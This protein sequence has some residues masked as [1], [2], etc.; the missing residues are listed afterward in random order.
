MDGTASLGGRTAKGRK[1]L[2][3]QGQDFRSRVKGGRTCRTNQSN[4]VDVLMLPETVSK[5]L[6]TIG[7][8]SRQ[9]KRI[10]GLTRLMESPILWEKAYSEIASNKGAL[11]RGVT[12]NTLDGFS[13]ER[14]ANLAERVRSGNHRFTPVRR[15]YIPKAN[16]KKRP[17]GVPT[18][19]D[20]L[21]QGV[22]K[23]LLELMYEPLFSPHSHGFRRNFSCHTA[24]EKIKN[25]WT[26]VKWF[27][28]VDVVG[29]FDNIDHDILIRLLEKRIDD[30]RFINLVRGM[31]KAGYMEDWKFH[32]TMSGTPQG[33]IVS[34]ILANIYLHEL[35]LFMEEM[36][37]RYD[38]GKMRAFT[39][40]YRTL[41][42]AIRLNR[43]KADRMFAQG[44]IT[45]GEQ[46]KQKVARLAA[47]RRSMPAKDGFDPNYRRLLF[48]RY[49][50]DF[51]IGIIGPK[52]EA[53]EIMQEVVDYLRRHL[54]LEASPEKS[55]ITK[56][57]RGTI[58]LGYGIKTA[59]ANRLR[60]TR[61]GGRLV[62]MR[63]PG[64]RIR[65]L[66]PSERT[67]RFN[68]EKGYGDLCR[69]KAVHRSY[70]IDSSALEIVM[71]YNAEM[72]G[73]ANYYRLA[74]F[75]KNDLRKLYFLWRTSLLRTLASKF[76]SS[77]SKVVRQFRAGREL[78]VSVKI[79]DKERGATVFTLKEIDQLPKLG[80]SV[81]IKPVVQFTKARS[82]VL[83]RL[84]AQVCEYCGAQGRPCEVHHVRRLVDMKGTELW[85]QVAAARRRKRVV[86]CRPCH[87]A[88]HAGK[89]TRKQVTDT[90]DRRA[91]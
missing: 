32:S 48:C 2:G 52:A 23:L 27:V 53:R 33:G 26:G 56:A 61:I 73:F 9:G 45:E 10:N 89:L 58:F 11:T 4:M 43:Q 34:P 68:R 84:K 5:R 76:R 1:A 37:A 59:T 21:V 67:I 51:L 71:A 20:K 82:D 14:M 79:R 29:F 62:L 63:S 70:L 18:A 6:E 72:R 35:D 91:G 66:V 87:R 86:L 8:L 38:R 36:K 28:D 50:D 42:A 55:K 49:A 17:L 74:Y 81:D 54:H 40:R 80:R 22:V 15:V 75:A 3:N 69:L 77:V 19:D 47:E 31:L 64:D 90:Q 78:A 44:N 16:G 85:Q 25:N 13:I 41:G 24:L 65:L 30:K 46:L 60:K 83:D 7:N 12:K 88:L 57:T 39:R